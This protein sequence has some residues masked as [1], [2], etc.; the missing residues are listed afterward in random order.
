MAVLQ[1][2]PAKQ[3]AALI[4]AE[5]VGGSAKEIA[6][7]LEISVAATRVLPFTHTPTGMPLDI[8]L[9]GPG[10]EELFLS[11]AELIE[12]GGVTVPVLRAEHLVVTKLLASRPKDIDDA[13]EVLSAQQGALDLSAIRTLLEDLEEALGHSDLLPA[14]D[15]LLAD[16]S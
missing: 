8:A 12:L 16:L 9:A 1:H 6:D 10:L 14:F 15:Q 4:L 2:L 13:R 3:R 7:C 11:E 5:V